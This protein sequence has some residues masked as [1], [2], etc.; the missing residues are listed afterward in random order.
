MNFTTG[1]NFTGMPTITANEEAS[2]IMNKLIK[3]SAST[4]LWEMIVII[5]GNSTVLP[6]ETNTYIQDRWTFKVASGYVIDVIN[7]FE[8]LLGTDQAL[9]HKGDFDSSGTATITSEDLYA[10]AKYL[11]KINPHFTDIGEA[12]TSE[13]NANNYW[14]NLKSADGTAVGINDLVY[15]TSMVNSVTGYTNF[16]ETGDQQNPL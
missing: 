13:G 16:P 5:F 10:L 2:N 14:A 11:V 12:I 1:P 15:L 6:N 4:T 9:R 3:D 8:L 7:G